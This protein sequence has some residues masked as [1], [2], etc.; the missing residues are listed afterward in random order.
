[1][2]TRLISH[3]DVSKSINQEKVRLR[4]FIVFQASVGVRRFAA[5]RKAVSVF[6]TASSD[7]TY[8]FPKLEIFSHSE[9]SRDSLF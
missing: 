9:T 2:R 3:A 7:V 5:K 6:L 4:R 1:M 8:I